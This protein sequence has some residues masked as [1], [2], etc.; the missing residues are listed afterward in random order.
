MSLSPYDRDLDR[1]PANFQLLTPLSL[2][3][4]AAEAL[5]DRL[6]IAHGLLRRNYR[7]FHAQTKKLA[8]ALAR[9]G[10]ALGDTVAVSLAHAPRRLGAIL[11]LGG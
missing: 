8:P 9:R 6:T 3:E 11:L 7:E 2:L 10:F 4:R 1:N 5:P